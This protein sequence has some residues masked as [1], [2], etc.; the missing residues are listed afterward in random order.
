MF[1]GLNREEVAALRFNARKSFSKL[2][3]AGSL[4][5]LLFFTFIYLTT[6]FVKDFPTH[7]L[8]LAVI[9]VVIVLFRMSCGYLILKEKYTGNIIWNI[10]FANNIFLGLLWAYLFLLFLYLYN[11]GWPTMFVGVL[12]VGYA[13]SASNNLKNE[14]SFCIAFILAIFVPIIIIAPVIVPSNRVIFLMI[15]F[16][17]YL[18]TAISVSLRGYREYWK[19]VVNEVLLKRK[20]LDIIGLQKQVSHSIKLASIGQLASGVAHEINNPLLIIQGNTELLNDML[21]GDQLN[22]ERIFSLN[23]STINSV[24]R[25]SRI[26]ES[27]QLYAKKDKNMISS[28]DLHSVI[29]DAI[30]LTASFIKR[31]NIKLEYVPYSGKLKVKGEYGKLQ[32]VFINLISNA[33]DALENTS[34]P[35]ILISCSENANRAIVKISD[36]GIGIPREN[37]GKVFDSFFTTKEIGKGTGLGLSIAY[38]I[39]NS[40]DATINVESEPAKGTCFTISLQKA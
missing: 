18:V 32:Q 35:I 14:I 26:V 5:V 16:L 25:I 13:A 6:D 23:N 17:L 27:L 20:T 4:I 33:R 11:T 12:V 36:N 34:N 2:S 10:H 3:I 15:A 8:W 19:R 1:T 24:N 9:A 39:L 22:Y 31:E 40:F 7:A 30:T 28:I 29:T 21:S 38:S 37:L